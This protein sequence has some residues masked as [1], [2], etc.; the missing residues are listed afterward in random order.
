[1]PQSSKGSKRVLNQSAN[2]LSITDKESRIKYVNKEF[3]QMSGY[4]SSELLNQ[5]HNVIRHEDMPKLAFSDMWAHL[6]KNKSWMGVVKNK[7]KNGDY[8]WIDAYASPIISHGQ[9]SEFQSVRRLP[10]A[11]VEARAD[12]LYQRMNSSTT[13]EKVLPKTVKLTF[14]SVLVLILL[15]YFVLSSVVY[16]QL[17]PWVAFSVNALLFIV[18][19]SFIWLR[20]CSIASAIAEAK[21]ISDS[22]FAAYIYTGRTDEAGFLS[23]AFTRL[24]GE[25]AAIVGRITDFSYLLKQKQSRVLE[26]SASSE[27]AL[28]ALSEDFSSIELSTSEMAAATEEIAQASAF[29]SKL[30]VLAHDK[31]NQGREAITNVRTSMA[32]VND[33]ITEANTQLEQL[34]LDSVAISSVIEVIQEV[35]E[36]TNLLALNAAIEAARAGEQGRGFAVVADE[37]RSLATRT[38]R[39]TEDIVQAIKRVQQGAL[40][41]C[42]KMQASMYAVDQASKQTVVADNVVKSVSEDLDQIQDQVLQTSAA[43]EQQ[44]GAAVSINSRITNA[45]TLSSGILERCQEN[46]QACEDLLLLSE[47]MEGV[48]SQFWKQVTHS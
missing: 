13:P 2:I 34:K 21:T 27:Q 10:H 24:R 42:D 22:S 26:S 14:F 25:A 29:S 40:L 47:Q 32:Q 43:M 7:C 23:L 35:A 45:V 41:A 31:M 5:Y 9:V 16:Y 44:S 36:Q 15:A 33:H 48:A 28:S 3:E 30:T 8:Y 18:S 37:V 46:T 11:E 4:E 19:L 1:M 39:S 17:S 38:Y 12:A 6:K 20:F